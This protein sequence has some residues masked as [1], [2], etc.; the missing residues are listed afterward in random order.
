MRKH[1]KKYRNAAKA[2]D[3]NVAL[4]IGDAVATV[5]KLAFA[6]FDESVDLSIKLNL[7][8]SQTVRDT[9]VLPFQFKA[10]KKILVFAKGEKAQEARDAGA[11]FVG[12][13]DLVDK[14]KTGWLDF[15]IAVATPDMM[16]E[17]G[18][19]GPILGRK[20]LMPNPKT[21]TVTLD[22]KGALAELRKGRTEFRSDK[23]GVIHLSVGKVSMEAS[24]VA[25]NV[26]A[27]LAEVEKK[28]P[29]DVKGD[30][31]ET[32]YV[33]STMGPGVKIAVKQQGVEK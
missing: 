24:Q 14:I 9:M 21:Q 10:E 2:V 20:G 7:K 28:K 11:A 4:P 31:M 3:R 13:D 5:K 27:L 17:V 30:Y 1:G 16:R 15:D 19:L 8:K 18:K 29:S 12:D 25:E 22:I 26:K 23:A 32:V 33:A 6:K